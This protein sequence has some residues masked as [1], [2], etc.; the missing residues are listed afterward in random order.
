MFVNDSV[1]L[2][3]DTLPNLVEAVFAQHQLVPEALKV[4]LDTKFVVRRS[5]AKMKSG[6]DGQIG[7]AH[8]CQLRND[9]LTTRAGM[10]N[11]KTSFC[12]IK[13]TLSSVNKFPNLESC[14]PHCTLPTSDG[15]IAVPIVEKLMR[16][17]STTK[18]QKA[19]FDAANVQTASGRFIDDV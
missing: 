5:I 16:N 15:G 11:E 8:K 6:R 10:G 19:K 1:N 13:D 3:L 17:E 14:S 18:T 2:T 7:F 12:L 4:A 9:A